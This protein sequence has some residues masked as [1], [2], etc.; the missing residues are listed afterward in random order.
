MYSVLRLFLL[1]IF[2]TEY[3]SD[4]LCLNK[5][6]GRFGGAMNHTFTLEIARREVFYIG[7]SFTG[8][9][10]TIIAIHISIELF[11]DNILHRISNLEE[12]LATT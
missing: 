8:V 11:Y 7:K 6:Q 5:T 9:K 4:Q 10:G 1:Q 2:H 3:I 12:V